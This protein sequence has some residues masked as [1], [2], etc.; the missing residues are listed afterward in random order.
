MW[1]L[2]LNKLPTKDNLL[3]R[4]ILDGSGILCDT[5]CGKEENVDHLFFQCEHY[6]KIWALISGWLGFVTAFQGTL[7]SHSTQFCGMGGLSKSCH[8]L[9]TTIWATTLFIIWKDRNS[10]VFKAKHATI[11]ALVEHI[12]LQSY[13][14]L[15]ANY[16][17]FDFD[18]S[19]WRNN[20]F[21]CR[22]AF[23]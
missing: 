7:S 9:L 6:G 11:E 13:W 2:F 1:R 20:P 21:H 8:I 10:R 5:L 15:K 3:R 12:K 19:F 23:V 4:G 14:W 17:L 16:V 22:Q 18:Y